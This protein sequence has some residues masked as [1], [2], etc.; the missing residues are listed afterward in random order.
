MFLG[1]IRKWVEEQTSKQY[2]FM[3]SASLPGARFP[4]LILALISLSGGFI[5]CKIK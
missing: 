1:G 3:V 5:S 2:S 4:T